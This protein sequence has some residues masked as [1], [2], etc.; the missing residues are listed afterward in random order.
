ML[1]YQTFESKTEPGEWRVE[2]IDHEG[3]GECYVAI[4]SGPHSRERATSYAAAMN[5]PRLTPEQREEG[6]R[7]LEAYHRYRHADLDNALGARGAMSA[8]MVE[9]ADALLAEPAT[10]D[11][12]EIKRAAV[13]EFAQTLIAHSCTDR[14][15]DRF[16]YVHDVIED[17]SDEWGVKLDEKR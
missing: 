2:A 14:N 9:H 7:L 6:R 12:A 17:A 10:I 3:D 5:A 8:W 4:F 11:V 1:T 15:N 16:V 13:R